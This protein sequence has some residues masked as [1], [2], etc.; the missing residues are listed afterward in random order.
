VTEWPMPSHR[1]SV[2]GVAFANAH[3]TAT[4]RAPGRRRQVLTTLVARRFEA[5]ADAREGGDERLAGNAEFELS[6]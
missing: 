5:V 6:P 3:S 2:H 1:C 4:P